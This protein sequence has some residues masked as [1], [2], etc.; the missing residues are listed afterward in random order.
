MRCD[1]TPFLGVIFVCLI[2]AQSLRGQVPASAFANFEARLTNP[3]RLSPDG[4]TLFAVNSADARLTV[5]NLSQPAPILS[6][7]IAV[8]VE[9]ISVNA[10]TNDE[11]WVVNELSDSIS[12]VS[13][14]SGVVTDT[15][16]VKDEPADV[17]FA[18]GKAFVSVAG[19]NEVRVF[20]ATTRAPV[21]TIPLLGQQPRA[22]AVSNDG[23]KVYVAFAESGNRTTLIPATQAPPQPSPTNPNLPAPPQVSLIVDATDPQWNPSVIKYNMPDNDVA[24]IDTGSFQVTRYFRGVGTLNLGLAVQPSTGDLF[25]T[26]TD[27][28]NL[29]RFEPT[30]RAHFVDNRVTRIAQANGALSIADLNAGIDYATL[31]NPAAQSTALAQPTSIAF[32]PSGLF[33]YVAA[34][35]SDRIARINGNGTVTSRIELGS[36]NSRSMRGPRGLALDSANGRLY[37]LNRISNTIQVINIATEKI[38]NEMPVGSFDPTPT[39]IKNGRGFLYDA[40]LSGNGTV[41]CA[42]CHLDGDSDRLAWDLGDRGG[43]MQTVTNKVSLFNFSA[44]FQMHPMKGPMRTQT[45]KGLTGMPPLH[46]RGDRS[47]FDAFNPAFDSLLGGP[48][49]PAADMTAFRE[50]IETMQFP[51]NPN[52]KLDRG[53]PA[54]IAGGNPVA[55]QH[56]FIAE[57]YVGQNTMCVQCHLAISGTDRSMSPATFLQASQDLKVPQLRNLYKKNFFNDSPGATSIDGFGFTHDGADPSLFRFLSH[58]VFPNIMNDATRKTNLSAFLLC[59]DTGTAPA[60]GYSRTVRSTNVNDSALNAD[61]NLLQSQAAVNNIDLIV[62]GTIDGR[63]HGLLYQP[64]TSNYASDKTGLGP[65]TQA[66]LK[67]KVQNGDSITFMGVAPGSGIRMGVDRDLNGEKDGDGAPFT[68]YSA[69]TAYW[70]T[71]AESANPAIGGLA[72][73]SDGD[74]LTNQMEYAQN[75]R[76]KFSDASGAPSPQFGGT[77]S[78]TFTKILDST[79]LDYVV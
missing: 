30:L 57:P 1:R 24:E 77:L 73:D 71:P 7:E 23:S 66:Q 41:S 18:A 59:F 55:G 40:R 78:L 19:N 70:L 43:Q 17:V 28:R 10:R 61:W 47:G 39:V 36:I 64:G 37:V 42:S 6:R 26:N 50:F 32:D 20:N 69:W 65:F 58:P 21:A 44:Q 51:P 3:I 22:M 74:G 46:W 60:V 2:A 56:T 11:V 45:L 63:L 12:I 27:A 9:P 48:Q 76:P 15:I 5:F 49:L 35:G 67:T 52:Q 75:L 14:S 31:P 62:K 16:Y 53:L 29:V 68:S 25:V 38:I 72:A 13:V 33:A 8:G 54:T 34:F 79:D 4:K